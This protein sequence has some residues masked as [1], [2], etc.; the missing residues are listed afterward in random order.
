MILICPLNNLNIVRGFGRFVESVV[1]WLCWEVVR[2]VSYSISGRTNWWFLF[3]PYVVNQNLHAEVGTNFDR[4]LRQLPD[5]FGSG[6]CEVQVSRKR[7][8]G[9]LLHESGRILTLDLE[10]DEE[11]E[12]DALSDGVMEQE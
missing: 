11:E 3:S 1:D 4:K 8:V 10:D 2:E 7:G 12:E 5:V 9:T 6:R